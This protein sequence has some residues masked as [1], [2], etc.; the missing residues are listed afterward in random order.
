M[1][2]NLENKL[3]LFLKAF[4]PK[5]VPFDKKDS[6]EYSQEDILKIIDS[7]L[8]PLF[9]NNNDE[10]MKI[11]KINYAKMIYKLVGIEWSDDP[12]KQ[13]RVPIKKIKKSIGK[14]DDFERDILAL[15]YGPVGIMAT[16]EGSEVNTTEGDEGRKIKFKDVSNSTL[17]NNSVFVNRQMSSNLPISRTEKDQ[18]LK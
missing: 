18:N 1:P 6:Y 3:D 2:T 15:L 4:V 8:E 14:A 12:A 5:D 13:Q 7:T 11:L 10:F 9:A 17:S 16:D